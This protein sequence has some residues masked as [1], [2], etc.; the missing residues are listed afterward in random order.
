MKV[1]GQYLAPATLHLVSL[2]AVPIK[3]EEGWAGSFEGKKNFCPLFKAILLGGI[4]YSAHDVLCTALMTHCVQRSWRIV[5]SAHD[6]LCTAFMTYCVQRSWRIVYSAH[7]ALCTALMTYCVQ[8]SWCIVYSARDALCT[9]L[10]TYCVQRSRRLVYSAHDALCT[11]LITYCVQRSSL[12]RFLNKIFLFVNF[13]Y[14]KQRLICFVRS[15]EHRRFTSQVCETTFLNYKLD[16]A[17][18][19]VKFGRPRLVQRLRRAQVKS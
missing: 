17:N 1:S 14:V 19:L 10:M 7:D 15:L 13:S 8:R 4:V 3:W 12:M 9:T 16:V 11:A 6:A 2:T 18:R 5:Y